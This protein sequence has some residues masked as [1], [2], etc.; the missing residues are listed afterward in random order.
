M[1]GDFHV[2]TTFCDG[3]AGAEEMVRAALAR[4]MDAVGFSGHGRTAFDESWCMSEAGTA[5]YRAEI[6]RLK[7]A[8]AGRISV[9]CAIERFDELDFKAF[10]AELKKQKI[11]LSLAQQDEWE[12][13]FNQ[14]K[15]DCNALSAQITA[16]DKEIDCVVYELYGLSEDEI[17]VV[18]GE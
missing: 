13:Y 3:Q 4:G 14:Y 9:F 18:E 2:H 15:A 16:T 7:K 10:V 11:I 17:K 5:A 1:T 6:A 8:Y 12:D